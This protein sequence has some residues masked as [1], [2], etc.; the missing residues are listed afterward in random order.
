MGEIEL[1]EGQRPALLDQVGLTVDRRREQKLTRIPVE[2]GAKQ[3]PQ[4]TSSQQKALALEPIA[5]EM[6]ALTLI[7]AH[8]LEKMRGL[9]PSETR[10]SRGGEEQEAS[11]PQAI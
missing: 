4:Q 9:T 7:F 3:P 10:R 5:D 8:H 1:N 6:V 2:Q 11:F